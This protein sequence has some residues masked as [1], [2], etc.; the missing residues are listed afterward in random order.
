MMKPLPG[1]RTSLK[2]GSAAVDN[3]ATENFLP[4][5]FRTGENCPA[6]PLVANASID[7]LRVLPDL[8]KYFRNF[9][10]RPTSK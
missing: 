1:S 7:L 9:A 2:R 3:P 4:L 8:A 10:Q 5:A 6:S